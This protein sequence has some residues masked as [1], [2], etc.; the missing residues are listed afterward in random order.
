M[1]QSTSEIIRHI[2]FLRRYARALT[3]TQE[4]GD[5]YV[6]VSLGSLLEDPDKLIATLQKGLAAVEDGKTAIITVVLGA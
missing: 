2:P 3:G 1:A 6:K 5:Y 4:Q